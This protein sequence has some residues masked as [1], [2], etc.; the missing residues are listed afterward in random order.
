MQSP[1]SDDYY[2]VSKGTYEYEVTLITNSDKYF[3][4]QWNNAEE[5]D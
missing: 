2:F 1:T 4:E 5:Q 3:V